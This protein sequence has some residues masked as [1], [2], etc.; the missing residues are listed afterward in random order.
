[1]VGFCVGIELASMTEEESQ[2][3]VMTAIQACR[4]TLHFGSTNW[5][6]H[7]G[8][9]MPRDPTPDTATPVLDTDQVSAV[10]QA[11]LQVMRDSVQRRAVLRGELQ[12]EEDA[13]ED[14]LEAHAAGQE[15]EA[16]VMFNISELLS[17]LMLTHRDA[18]MEVYP[19]LIHD[20][21]MEMG[22]EFC[23]ATDRRI[24]AFVADDVLEHGGA[25]GSQ[26]VSVFMP[27]LI[28]MCSAEDPGLR[29]AGLYGIIQAAQKHSD[30]FAP[31][32]RDAVQAVLSALNDYGYS[33]EHHGEA[34]D[35]GVSALAIMCE[36]FPEAVDAPTVWAS[37]LG[38]L[39]LL[40]DVEESRRVTQCLCRLIT[41]G[42]ANLLGPELERLQPSM[43]AVLNAVAEPRI[44]TPEL[45]HMVVAAL[46][47]PQHVSTAMVGAI[48][49]VWH[50]MEPEERQRYEDVLHSTSRVNPGSPPIAGEIADVLLR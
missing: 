37:L 33:D 34:S 11:L 9:G 32:A 31:F 36:N 47:S 6:E 45:L 4:V 25:L 15:L 12:L 28:A 44:C 18:Y 35:N 41:C 40:I 5:L 46:Y 38:H 8:N 48:R 17:M 43:M 21:V 26:F 49:T 50:A 16:E 7:S 19:K 30:A 23:L 10:V 39:P 2:D 13:D 20:K 29:Q 14:D 3:L 1:M 27:M 24:A 22:S 42:D